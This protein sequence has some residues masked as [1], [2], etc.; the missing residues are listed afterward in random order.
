MIRSWL[1]SLVRRSGFD[2]VHRTGDPVLQ[3]LLVAYRQLRLAPNSTLQ[4]E[5]HLPHLAS[6]SHLRNLLREQAIDLVI[7][8]GA[9]TGQFAGLVRRVGYAGD[10]VSFEPLSSARKALESRAAGDSRWVVRPEA[11]GRIRGMGTLLAYTNSTFSSFNAINEFG[12]NRFGAQVEA[13]GGERVEIT[14]LDDL[15]GEIARN[16]SRRILLKTDTQG[17]DLEVLAGAVGTLR[18]A[19]AVLAEAST[20]P[21]Y[22]RSTRLTDLLCYLEREGFALSGLFPTGHDNPP[23]MALLELDCYFV[24]TNPT[25]VPWTSR[26]R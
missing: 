2:L 10:I 26:A 5:S 18:D 6:F 20:I 23:G 9:N 19:R 3:E 1:K 15:I 21:I 17:Y 4:W 25:M 11:L 8:I 13:V 12:R 24:R 22:D 16:G 7:D 14:P